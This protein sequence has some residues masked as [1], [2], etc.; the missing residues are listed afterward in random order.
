MDYKLKYIKYKY[1]YQILQKEGGALTE[2]ISN[3]REK[4]RNFREKISNIAISNPTIV[5]DK[6][7]S[8]TGNI[9]N[10]VKG[11]VRNFLN[12]TPTSKSAA[13]GASAIVT[14]PTLEKFEEKYIELDDRYHKLLEEHE[15]YITL[16]NQLLEEL[17]KIESKSHIFLDETKYTLEEA[18]N[19]EFSQHSIIHINNDIFETLKYYMGKKS[20]IYVIVPGNAGLPGGGHGMH[21]SKTLKTFWDLCEGDEKINDED[22]KTSDENHKKLVITVINYLYKN[23]MVG[24]LFV[25]KGIDKII[26][27]IESKKLLKNLNGVQKL[28]IKLIQLLNCLS[29][30]TLNNI[31]D[32][33]KNPLEEQIMRKWLR[34]IYI[35]SKKEEEQPNEADKLFCE[36]IGFRWGLMHELKNNK[37]EKFKYDIEDEKFKYDIEDEKSKYNIQDKEYTNPDNI[38]NEEYTN[39]DNG[40]SKY[41]LSYLIENVKFDDNVSDSSINLLFTFAPNYA[42]EHSDNKPFL[43][44]IQTEQKFI[45]GYSNEN[46]IKFNNMAIAYCIDDCLSKCEEG[47]IVLIP[48]L[49]YGVNKCYITSNKS[50]NSDLMFMKI[51]EETINSNCKHREKMLTII[52]T[53]LPPKDKSPT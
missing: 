18:T 38:Q 26:S 8:V 30:H 21:L 10:S 50:E 6:I 2:K 36:T 37:K 23:S 11:K 31:N 5:T 15:H 49:G 7:L 13:P 19:K 12:S 16:T 1:K 44:G 20:K 39:P 52:Y 47:S 46:K 24:L 41:K 25:E 35:K 53:T 3:I 34:K 33:T 27:D 43:T 48:K 4:I 32:D 14:L 51:I 22:E 42:T 28:D 29:K 9:S 17:A 40:A 45:E